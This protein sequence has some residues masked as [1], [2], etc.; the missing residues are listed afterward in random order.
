M[1]QIRGRVAFVL[2]A[3]AMSGGGPT[4]ADDA[5]FELLH[6]G[7]VAV[8]WQPQ[9]VDGYSVRYRIADKDLNT[10]NAVNCQ[11]MRSPSALFS[12]SGITDKDF[13]GA[14][15]TAFRRWESVA[16]I[17]FREASTLDEADIVVGAQAVPSG[18]AFTD[19]ALAEASQGD[20]SDSAGYRHISGAR[21]CLN[22]SIRWKIG[23]DGD[24]SV[25][26][27]VHTLTHEI[28]HA[29]GLDH[30]NARGEVMSFR[31]DETHRELTLGDVLGAV[32]IYGWRSPQ[33]AAR[34]ADVSAMTKPQARPTLASGLA[35]IGST[36]AL[37]A[38]P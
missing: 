25:Y 16:A 22:P 11:R 37:S 38:H 1:R 2:A 9:G 20:E 17:T 3:I 7:G 19:V 21:I 15:A 10:E 31:Y 18:R 29:I 6:I 35:P 32:H 23:F 14:L 24:L 33:I 4:K 26:D 8:R 27:L 12:I 36:A 5:P 30:P 28:G 34:F 13:R